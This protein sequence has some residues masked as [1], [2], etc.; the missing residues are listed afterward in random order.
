MC[1]YILSL[2]LEPPALCRHWAPG[3]AP[4]VVQ[5]PPTSC[6]SYTWQCIYAIAMFSVCSSSRPR[7]PMSFHP[8]MSLFWVTGLSHRGV[9]RGLQAGAGNNARCIDTSSTSWAQAC[10]P[11]LTVEDTCTLFCLNGHICLLSSQPHHVKVWVFGK[12]NI[13]QWGQ[14]RNWLTREEEI[15]EIWYS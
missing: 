12:E 5:Q 9:P 7:P 6:P 15:N 1:T 13:V 10:G 8:V 4:C 3:W 11:I 14:L 2:P